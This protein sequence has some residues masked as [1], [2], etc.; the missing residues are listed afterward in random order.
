ME[1]NAYLGLMKDRLIVRKDPDPILREVSQVI[2]VID[3]HIKSFMHALLSVMHQEHGMGIAAIQ[4]GVPIR[5]FIVNLGSDAPTLFM[6]NPK[7]THWS[8]QTIILPEGCLSVKT[9]EDKF[10]RGHVERPKHITITY[11]DLDNNLQELQIDGDES[12]YH[13]WL[14]RCIQHEYDHL[15]GILFTDKVIDN[16]LITDE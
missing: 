11:T 6:I 15:D 12:E 16:D 14:A 5:A 7:I 2:T 8:K 3:K 1:G 10:Q 9:F 13:L 4:V